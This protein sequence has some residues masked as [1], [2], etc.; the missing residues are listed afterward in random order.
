MQS[1]TKIDAGYICCATGKHW[2]G[3]TEYQYPGILIV[4]NS[5]KGKCVK[6]YLG[7]EIVAT[8]SCVNWERRFE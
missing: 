8:G 5:S 4:D 6:T 1:T 7:G 3:P 2:T